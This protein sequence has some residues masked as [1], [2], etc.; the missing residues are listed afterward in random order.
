MEEIAG[1]IKKSVDYKVI[2]KSREDYFNVGTIII[3]TYTGDIL[4]IPST[5]FI[6]SQ[7]DEVKKEIDHVSWHASGRVSIKHKNNDGEK[8]IIV[9]KCGERQKISEI[10]FQEILKDLIKNFNELP[11][12][13]K[14]IT[15]LDVVLNANDYFGLI[16]FNF[17]IV[18]GRLIV[19]KF[20]GQKVPIKPVNI[21]EERNGL[22]ST[23]RALG[24]HSGSGDVILQYSLRKAVAENLRTNRQIFIP[25]DMK[26]SK[27]GVKL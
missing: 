6:D 12:Y 5:K 18:S 16:S 10:G 3:R 21:K 17:S 27:L 24:H 11:K 15:P 14:Q 25:H 20:R 23:T 8:Y 26:I 13:Q 22:D 7:N 2:I 19:A 4:Y 9:Q 1:K